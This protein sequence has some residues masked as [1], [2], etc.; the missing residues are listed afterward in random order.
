[1]KMWPRFR[2]VVLGLCAFSLLAACSKGGT[3]AEPD[4][5]KDAQA[6]AQPEREP[7]PAPG[8]AKDLS[9]PPVQIADLK[10]GLQVNTIVTDQ[11]PVV[12]ATLV[13]RSGG[14][15]DPAKLPGLSGL[16]AQMLKEGTTKRSSAEI[17]EEIEFLGADLW[18]SSDEENTYVGVRAL[19]EQ[20]DVAMGIL[21]EVAGK[22]SF[23]NKELEK[24]KKRELDR[25]ALSERE[26]RYIAR[27]TFYRQLYGKHP[28]GTVDTTPRAVKRVRRQDLVR[29]HREHF[30]GKNAFLVVAG[31]VDPG[32]VAEA[33]R[34][35][36]GAWNA[37]KRAVPTYGDPP[38]PT[39]RSILVVDRPGSV[40]SVIYI[41]NLAIA[42]A[43]REWIPLVVSN[44]VLGGSAASR[45]FMDL[46][47]KRS[48]TYGAYSAIGEQVDIGP[49]VAYASVR[50]EVTTEAIGAFFEHLVRI[51][52]EPA[53]PQELL[54]AKRYLSDSF[55]LK[56][57][58]PGKLSELVVEL[59]TFGLPDDY[60]DN[61]RQSI[62]KTS[63][64]EAQYVA[65]NYIRPKESL[66]VI[67]G[68]A[69]D[70]AQSLQ[71]FGPVTVISPDGEVK[72]KFE[73]KRPNAGAIGAP[74]GPID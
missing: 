53:E 3:S 22:P 47:E 19:T 17:A 4:T 40:Q 23:S 1:M 64:S 44:Q 21:A 42:R 28:Y 60:W 38:R 41:G 69:A 65:R 11:L 74:R 61:Y 6:K 51:N 12:Y 45:L 58:T 8:E 16:V 37:G 50:T 25:L 62:R 10:N 67:V 2:L 52:Q 5:A 43:N 9:L 66:V 13:I 31:D 48:L 29:W 14:E 70:F 68:Q 20:F 18:A 24:L 27:R 39:D 34:Q 26:P 54:N 63:A 57:D 30:V 49:F 7:P 55:P 33:A 32:Q 46:R 59:R 72:A 15:S 56:V 36:F 73:D 71:Q 35:M